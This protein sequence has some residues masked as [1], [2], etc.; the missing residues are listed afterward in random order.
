MRKP[1]IKKVNVYEFIPND[2]IK[3]AEIIELS[4]IIRIGVGSETVQTMSEEL[5]KFFR[6]VK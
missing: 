6:E 2:N 1:K 5:K 4:E 3:P